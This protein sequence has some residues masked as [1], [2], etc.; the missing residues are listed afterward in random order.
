MCVY[1][2]H[3]HSSLII[4]EGETYIEDSCKNKS[5]SKSKLL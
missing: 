2:F 4:D 1:Q 5:K 3:E